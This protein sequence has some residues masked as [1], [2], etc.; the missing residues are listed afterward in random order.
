TL[1]FLGIVTDNWPR[2]LEERN[3]S[4]PAAHRSAL[5]RL[6]AARLKRNPPGGPVIAAGSTGSIP[7]TAELLAVIAGLPNGAVVLPGLDSELDDA[8]FAAIT[9]PGARPATLGHPQYGLA[10]LIGGMRVQRRDVEAIGAAAPHL[11]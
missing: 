1:D 6:V 10:K 9:A 3:R 7:A 2:L 5:I 8:S 4:N 11:A